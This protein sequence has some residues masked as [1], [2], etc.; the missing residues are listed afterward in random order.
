MLAAINIVA[1]LAVTRRPWRAR[2]LAWAAG[3]AVVVAGLSLPWILY[4]S[5]LPSTGDNYA[6]HLN[7]AEIISQRGRLPVILGAMAAELVNW[8]RWGLFWIVLFMVTVLQ[9]RGV[10]SRAIL[11]L[12]ILL[13][14]HLIGYVPP[15]L[16]TTWDLGELLKYSLSRL[17]LHAAPAGALLIG[18]EWPRGAAMAHA[19][20]SKGVTIRVGSRVG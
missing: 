5:H 14:V 12:W 6:A 13:G 8:H 3:F 7:G 15:Y 2:G 18:L 4:A 20:A 1:I 19:G 16:V 10:F 11:T 9:G 17:V